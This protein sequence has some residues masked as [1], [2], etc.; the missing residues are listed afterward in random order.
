MLIKNKVKVCLLFTS[1]TNCDE[2]TAFAFEKADAQ[3]FTFH[4]NYLKRNKKILKEFHILCLP[5]GFTYGDYISAGKI[6]AQE[7]QHHFQ[8][9]IKEFIKAGKLILGICNGFQVLCK[10]GL[11]PGFND[12]FIYPQVT[13]TFNNSQKFECC[14][15]SL[16]VNH[17]SKTPFI[18]ELDEVIQLPIAHAEGKFFTDL[19]EVLKILKDN[20]Q[21]ALTYIENPNGSI[22]DI[23]GICDSTGQI[24]GLMPHPERFIFPLHHPLRINKTYGLKFFINACEY[25]KKEL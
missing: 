11:L 13:L 1:G 3:V 6:L 25:A 23:A 21:I 2:E 14:W 24:F 5:G 12:Y 17:N 15:V 20:N 8:E 16:R 9:E 19:Q 4:I 22:Y 7:L 18:K 10:A